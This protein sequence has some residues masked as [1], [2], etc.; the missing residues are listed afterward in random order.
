MGNLSVEGVEKRP[1][2]CYAGI[3]GH[4]GAIILEDDEEGGA[5]SDTFIPFGLVGWSVGRS[6]RL[7]L[8]L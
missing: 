5:N 4:G 1:V 3:S 6:T 8:L 7:T 2:E